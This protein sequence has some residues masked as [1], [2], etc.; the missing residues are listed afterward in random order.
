VVGP[1][2]AAC[3]GGTHS[4]AVVAYLAG[5]AQHHMS[6]NHTACCMLTV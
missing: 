5:T 2:V 3:Q 4:P 6:Y 1:L